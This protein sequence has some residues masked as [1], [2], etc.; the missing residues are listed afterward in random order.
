MNGLKKKLGMPTQ[1]VK[2]CF[3]LIYKFII[4]VNLIIF[5]RSLDNE[6]Y[7]CLIPRSWRIDCE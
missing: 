7:H 4:L 2:I 6:L 5:K 3:D 1:W